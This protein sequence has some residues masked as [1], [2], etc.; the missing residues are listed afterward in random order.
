VQGLAITIG[1]LGTYQY[2][3]SQNLNERSTRAMVF[4]TLIIAN[5]VLTLV[6]RSFYYSIITTFKYKNNLVLLII[7]IT[8]GITSLILFI[9]PFSKFFEF[10]SLSFYQLSFCLIVGSLSVIWYEGV[11]LW[12]RKTSKNLN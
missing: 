2:A 8:L 9:K 10:E 7:A 1:T 11:K 6:N 3:I 4:T 5:V 12:K